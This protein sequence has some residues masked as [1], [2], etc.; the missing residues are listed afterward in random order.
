MLQVDIEDQPD[1]KSGYKI[2]LVFNEN[3]YFENSE[4]VRELHFSDETGLVI[5]ST[6]I[7]WKPGMVSRSPL[8]A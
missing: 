6:S 2:R 7:E 5:E 8:I 1:I 3:P 4:L